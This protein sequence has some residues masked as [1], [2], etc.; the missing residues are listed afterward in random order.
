M[1]NRAMSRAS[2]TVAAVL[3]LAASGSVFAQSSP[4]GL[5]RTIDDAT[6]KPKSLLRITEVNGVFSGKVEKLLADGVDPNQVCDK[7]TD[8]R[9]DKPIVG[10]VVL[11]DLKAEGEEFS[12]GKILDPNNGKVYSARAKLVDGGKKLELRG[13]IGTPLLGRTQTWQRAD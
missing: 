2:A 11:T 3:M 13:Y 4:V 10:M 6:G 5:W 9:K 12:N 7:C 8:H 1:I